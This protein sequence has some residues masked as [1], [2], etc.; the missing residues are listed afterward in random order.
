M[1]QVTANP[2]IGAFKWKGETLNVTPCKEPPL[3]REDW[4]EYADCVCVDDED[5]IKADWHED[6][7]PRADNG[8]FGSGAKKNSLTKS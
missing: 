7:H 8:E 6:D 2:P 5:E 3:T 1:N 4:I